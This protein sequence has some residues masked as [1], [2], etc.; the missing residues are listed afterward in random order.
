MRVHNMLA[1][2]TDGQLRFLFGCDDDLMCVLIL[3]TC[4]LSAQQFAL[5]FKYDAF[6]LYFFLL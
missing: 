1:M 2:V 4:R 3:K 5:I 6:Y